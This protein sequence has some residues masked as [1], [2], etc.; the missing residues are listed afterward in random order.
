MNVFDKLCAAPAF[1]LGIGLLILGLLGL[2]AGCS[3]HFTLPP[4]FGVI[5]A[6]IGWGILRA[7]VVAWNAGKSVT[8][9]GSA[10]LGGNRPDEEY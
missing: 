7:V 9:R 3:A 2:F 5:P 8:G 6:F 10:P 1:L 4:I